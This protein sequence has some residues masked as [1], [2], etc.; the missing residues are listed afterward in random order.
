MKKVVK[1]VWIR[2]DTLEAFED[3]EQELYSLL[4]QSKGDCKV[5]VYL[6][7]S[8]SI[9]RLSAY[10]FDKDK[11]DILSEAFGTEN[12]RVVER[13]ETI[14][15]YSEYQECRDS[16]FE[17]MVYSLEGIEAAL[18]TIAEHLENGGGN[19]ASDK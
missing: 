13:E 10:P 16:L 1:K 5:T 12:V 6:Q 17:R 3:R 15:T 2:F 11:V 4:E 18:N 9:K 8:G 7:D 19:I 14:H